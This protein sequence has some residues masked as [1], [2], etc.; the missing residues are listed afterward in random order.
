MVGHHGTYPV[1]GTGLVQQVGRVLWLRPWAALWGSLSRW[2]ALPGDGPREAAHPARARAGHV[3]VAARGRVSDVSGGSAVSAPRDFPAFLHC[4]PKYPQLCSPGFQRCLF[5]NTDGDACSAPAQQ[6]GSPAFLWTTPPHSRTSSQALGTQGLL[7]THGESHLAQPP[8]PAPAWARGLGGGEGRPAGICPQLVPP[9]PT[10]PGLPPRTTER[11][12][13][14]AEF[15]GWNLSPHSHRPE[16]SA[17][18]VRAAG[19]EAALRRGASPAPQARAHSGRTRVGAGSV[20]KWVT[21]PQH[22]RLAPP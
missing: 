9:C 21:R 8:C 10:Y 1:T 5:A 20:V 14:V 17:G 7:G 16:A 11:S 3:W 4:P 13:P 2:A 12:V 22:P 18:A 15:R 19:S 6:Q